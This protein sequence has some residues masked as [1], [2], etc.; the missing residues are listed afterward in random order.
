M[1]G[2]G[3]TARRRWW[4][5]VVAAWTVAVAVGGGLTLVLQE[6]ARPQRPHVWEDGHGVGGPSPGARRLP[7]QPLGDD[8]SCPPSPPA[9]TAPA[10]GHPAVICLYAT[11]TP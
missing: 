7:R 8:P 2:P 9:R 10:A 11:A 5:W 3:G 6:D 1:T 4:R